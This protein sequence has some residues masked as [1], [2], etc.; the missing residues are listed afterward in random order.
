MFYVYLLQ[1]V[2]YALQHYVGLSNN[3]KERLKDHNGGKSK[4]TAKYKPWNLICYFA[5]KKERTAK[6][7]EHYLKTGSG[8][9][10]LKKHFL[11]I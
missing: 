1:S 9:A 4:H 11:R 5:F 3:L 8:R 7:F 10:F 6:E 2:N